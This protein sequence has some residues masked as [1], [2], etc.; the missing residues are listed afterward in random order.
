MRSYKQLSCYSSQS[1]RTTADSNETRT[2]SITTPST[3][4]HAT[5]P[6]S[7]AVLFLKVIPENAPATGPL[8]Q[9]AFESP[10]TRS[11]KTAYC[12][13]S[14]ISLFSTIAMYTK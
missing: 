7:D 4:S 14:E 5:S 9:H 10:F 3:T 8:D 6:E 12:L 11:S 13:S 2:E 1:V